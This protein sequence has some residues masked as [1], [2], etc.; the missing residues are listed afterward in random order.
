MADELNAETL[1]DAVET[2]FRAWLKRP[3]SA[4]AED[5]RSARADL[6]RAWNR[7]ATTEPGVPDAGALADEAEDWCSGA[8]PEHAGFNVHVRSAAIAGYMS[9]HRA[10]IAALRAAKGGNNG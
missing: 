2:A 6:F 4:T 8:F 1:L 3:T 9:G 7:R 10:A 5:W